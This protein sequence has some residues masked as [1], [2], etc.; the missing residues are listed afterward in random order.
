MKNGYISIFPNKI[1]NEV[2]NIPEPYNIQPYCKLQGNEIIFYNGEKLKFEFKQV[3]P[4][5]NNNIQISKNQVSII[6][7]LDK[8][9]AILNRNRKKRLLTFSEAENEVKLCEYEATDGR[10]GVI[11][12]SKF[13]EK[14]I[15]LN[16]KWYK[17]LTPD[18]KKTLINS[19]EDIVVEFA[20]GT[21]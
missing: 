9:K 6:K 2:A 10:K 21:S 4:P 15:F 14:G 19:R 8:E 5:K 1:L 7:N 17:N 13:M 16:K 12:W 18:Q 3:G 20:N 11:L